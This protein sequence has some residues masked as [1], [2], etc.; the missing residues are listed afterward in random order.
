[1]VAQ[2]VDLDTRLYLRSHHKPP[3]MGITAS[4]FIAMMIHLVAALLW[5]PERRMNFPQLPDWVNVKLVA[6]F[7]DIPQVKPAKKIIEPVP[8]KKTVPVAKEKLVD[9]IQLEPQASSLLQHSETRKEDSEQAAA[10][11]FVQ[12]DSRPFEL[13]N[14]KPVFPLAARRS[15]MQGVVLLQVHV[16]AEGKVDSVHLMRSSG[17]RILD[18]SAISTVKKWKFMP[19]RQDQRNVASVVEVPIRFQLTGK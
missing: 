1:M 4:V 17:F 7:E 10:Q 19:A 9:E 6:G 3:V 5:L 16:S 12:A 2:E 14:P 11:N 18:I 13:Q 8:V 15:G